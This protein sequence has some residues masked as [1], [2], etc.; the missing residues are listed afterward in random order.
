[1]SALASGM[2]FANLFRHERDPMICEDGHAVIT[3][4]GPSEDMYVV[5]EG[6]VDIVVG[7]KTVETVVE[8]GVFGEMSI[9]DDELASASAI[10]K[11]GAKLARVD[12]HRFLFLI[13]NHPTF[14][15]EIMRVMSGRLRH[16]DG[17]K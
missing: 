11:G 5:L 17:Q 2:N 7:G 6:A 3:T 8:G 4:G 9:V 16:M 10:V 13:Q 15:L 1:M 12:H 14:A